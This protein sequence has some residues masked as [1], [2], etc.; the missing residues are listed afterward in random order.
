MHA[1][2]WLLG[3]RLFGRR[4]RA[5]SDFT[6]SANACACHDGSLLLARITAPT[7]VWG[8]RADRLFPVD[9]VAT[10]AAAL[11]HATLHLVDGPH[12]AF[13][14]RRSEFHRTIADFIA[15]TAG[16]PAEEIAA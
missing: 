11:P 14:Q 9:V 15:A 8:A 12:A 10:L 13:L 5:A 2:G 16:Q 6:A 3:S 7:L 1:L 4:E